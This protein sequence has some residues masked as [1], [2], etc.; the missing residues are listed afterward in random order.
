MLADHLRLGVAV[1]RVEA[2]RPAGHGLRHGHRGVTQHR[3]RESLSYPATHAPGDAW[4]LTPPAGLA[5]VVETLA[6]ALPDAPATFSVETRPVGGGQ[7]WCRRG[8]AG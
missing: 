4:P 8:R 2:V 5:L 7:T 6:R 3:A 1:T